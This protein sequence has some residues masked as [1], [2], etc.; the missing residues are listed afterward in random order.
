[1]RA[2]RSRPEAAGESGSSQWFVV[3]GPDDRSGLWRLSAGAVVSVS[4]LVAPF[5]GHTWASGRVPLCP[6]GGERTAAKPPPCQ[7]R[8]TRI[9]GCSPSVTQPSTA[10]R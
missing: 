5:S 8:P 3:P 10:L 6:Q 2:S 7:P 9:P 1:M 4:V